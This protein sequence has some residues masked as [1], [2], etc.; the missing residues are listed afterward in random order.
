MLNEHRHILELSQFGWSI[1][2]V[3]C[4]GRIV[5]QYLVDLAYAAKDSSGDPRR[6]VAWSNV[7]RECHVLV[8]QFCLLS[9]GISYWQVPTQH[10]ELTNV[11]MFRQLMLLCVTMSLTMKSIWLLVD[12]YRLVKLLNDQAT[13]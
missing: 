1:L 2:G 7:R 13:K 5:F 3:L 8:G 11:V 6:F 10:P 12:R 4:G 9:V